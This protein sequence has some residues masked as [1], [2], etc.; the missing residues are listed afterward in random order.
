MRVKTSIT[1]PQELLLRVDSFTG[2]RHKRSEVIEAALR[3]YLRKKNLMERDQREMEII[4][5]NAEKL[6][7]E[8][9]DVL[10]YQQVSW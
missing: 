9:L 7:E 1:L 8:A 4:N 2:K 3:E 10:E 6:N 5:S